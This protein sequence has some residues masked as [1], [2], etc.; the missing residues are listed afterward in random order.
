MRI[1]KALTIFIL[2]IIGIFVLWHSP[3]DN[4]TAFV[5]YGSGGDFNIT[6]IFPTPGHDA[7]VN[8]QN[9]TVKI[10][11][12]LALST[13][14][15]E[16]NGV[17]ETMSGSGQI[18]ELTKSASGQVNYKVYAISANLSAF[19][20]TRTV[21]SSYISLS[22]INS[23]TADEDT[24][25]SSIN[26]SAYVTS[27]QPV[28]F[29]FSLDVDTILSCSI[30]NEILSCTPLPN[31]SGI[32]TIIVTA[33]D[34]LVTDSISFSITLF[35]INDMPYIKN[36][37]GDEKFTLNQKIKIKLSQ[38]FDDV[39]SSLNYSLA[40]Y[41]I[42]STAKD[43]DFKFNLTN[44]EL[45]ITPKQIGPYNLAIT[46]TDN[47]GSVV[48]TLLLNVTPNNPPTL[49]SRSPDIFMITDEIKSIDLDLYF[50]YF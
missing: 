1:A 10:N 45:F 44:G 30:L 34:T 32:T 26:L 16:W 24:N 39:D 7:V 4:L 37:I 18:W 31:A 41:D 3:G 35:P 21:I 8:A 25:L 9:L 20:E 50:S 19:S 2:L 23:V 38:Y 22:A 29:S 36:V 46:A 42:N 6:F 48:Q 40:V 15:L 33:D 14:I 27:S 47:S 28:Q 43:D 49:T 5:V 12:E 11:A 13:A 17:N